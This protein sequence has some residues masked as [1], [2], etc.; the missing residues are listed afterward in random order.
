MIL[1]SP[2]NRKQINKYL[3]SVK[4][5][6]FID[7]FITPF[8]S[9][10]G[11]TLFRHN[12]HGPGEHGKDIIFYRHVQIFDDLEYLAI[13]AKAQPISASNVVD[14][15]NQLKRALEVPF[16]L[17]TRGGRMV[18][19]Y[20]VL[21]NA[22]R[23]NNEATEVLNGLLKDESHVKVLSQENV[24]E[25]ILKSGIAPRSLLNQLSM[26]ISSGVN[27]EDGIVFKTLTSGSPAEIDDLL[28]NK[29]PLMRK[30]L[31]EKS[32]NQVIEYIYHRWMQ[33]R[34]WKGT[35]K[36]MRWLN[37]YFNF[38]TEEQYKYLI[39][40]FEECS[41]AYP[42]YDARSDT[43]AIVNKVKPE[44]LASVAEAFIRLCGERMLSMS[45]K[46]MEVLVS[47]LRELHESGLI[48]DDYLGAAMDSII[49]ADDAR[50][51]GERFLSSE[52]HKKIF[53]F[54]Y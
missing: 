38:L 15:S 16:P 41:T 7:D 26:D 8:Y 45:Y 13:Q 47:K 53:E 37:S 9:S 36:P 3:E 28:D 11:F 5:D 35:V 21:V 49:K 44:Q 1:N 10:N 43:L 4:E 22:R 18:P 34:S 52:Y 31:S 50:I 29:L 14:L 54:I 6:E 19:D 30:Y 23:H 32:K 42:S 17:R 2:E 25:L 46:N 20:V 51:Q 33:D 24:C 40:V 27:E 39:P 12:S 48:K